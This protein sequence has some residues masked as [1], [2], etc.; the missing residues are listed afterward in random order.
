MMEIIG[1]RVKIGRA[2]II[3][4][5][6]LSV[7]DGEVVALVGPN[8]AGKTTTLKAVVGLIRHEGKVVLDGEDLSGLDAGGRARRGVGYSPEDRGLFPSLTV[9]ENLMLPIKALGLPRERLELALRT[10]EEVKRFLDRRADQLSGG[11]QKLVALARAI[12]VGR[13]ALLLDEVFE[14]LA[15]K[16]A[17]DVALYLKDYLKLERPAVILAEST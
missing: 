6:N 11:Q 5:V 2:E 16:M 8:G 14:G 1:L 7:R 12:I 15:P 10:V 3:R 17:G 4:G 13:R 9:R